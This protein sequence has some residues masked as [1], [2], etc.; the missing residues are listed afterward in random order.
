MVAKR[1][2]MVALILA[3]SVAVKGF[4]AEDGLE[5]G[6]P[7]LKSAGPMAFGPN[8]ILFLGDPKAAAI[9]AVATGDTTGDPENVAIN[10]PKLNE[11]IAS[12][13]GT[14]PAQ[15]QIADLAVNP[16]SGNVYLSV[17]RGQGPA[18][19]PIVLK[20]DASGKL[21]EFS[22]K[23]VRFAK[24]DL[25]NP[26]EDKVT[27]EGRRKANNREVSITDMSYIDGRVV[28][29][30][31][32]NE[33]F[34]SNLRAIEFPFTDVNPGSSVEI[35]HGNH[36]GLETRSPIRTFVPVMLD[37]KPE[38]VAA[39]T[40]TPLVRFPLSQ[41]KPGAKVRGT[42]VAELGNHNR[43]LD[44]IAY[45]KGG[46]EFLLMANNPRGMMK[47][48]TQGLKT[49]NITK[50]VN[51]EVAGLKYDTIESLKAVTQMDQLNKEH[52]VVLMETDGNADLQTIE[53]P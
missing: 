27:G 41:L 28:V 12:L 10:V 3:M 21:S 22:L 53:L 39:Y 37:G 25:P 32:S 16:A 35:F 5:K 49:D 33:D 42:T 2:G 13:L 40:C 34:A 23:N 45:K 19:K 29:A 8:G 51:A 4:A 46:K 36:G 17:S 14:K 43:P 38:I 50:K 6:T 24:A 11:K 52:A 31:L 47:I 1:I 15:I 7:Q 48:D 44:I 26:P 18:A 20:V 30:G 9:F